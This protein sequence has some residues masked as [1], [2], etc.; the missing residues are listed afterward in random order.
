MRRPY[1]STGVVGGASLKRRIYMGTT[2]LTHSHVLHSRPY[3]QTE[4]SA[5]SAARRCYA[6]CY[7][8]MLVDFQNT[9]GVLTMG[10][11]QLNQLNLLHAG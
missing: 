2:V 5:G 10:T 9:R 4:N 6:H 11:M 8:C 1:A 3:T 7:A